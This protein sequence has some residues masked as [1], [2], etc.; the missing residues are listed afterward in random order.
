MITSITLGVRIYGL[1]GQ[2]KCSLQYFAITK[3]ALKV[4]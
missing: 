2:Q 4:C 3:Y 1:T